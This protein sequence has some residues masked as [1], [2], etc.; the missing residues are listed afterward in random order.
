MR[1]GEW[2][3]AERQQQENQFTALETW[4]SDWRSGPLEG[5]AK[6]S[7]LLVS[8][9][10]WINLY[11]VLT[12]IPMP[13]L[14]VTEIRK[15]ILLAMCLRGLPNAPTDLCSQANK[16]KSQKLRIRPGICPINPRLGFQDGVCSQST[17]LARRVG[18]KSTKPHSAG[19]SVSFARK[20]QL[21]SRHFET[22]E[23]PNWTPLCVFLRIFWGL[24]R[25]HSHKAGFI[26][27]KSHN[28]FK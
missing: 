3:Y 27:D 15:A 23:H 26:S 12:T 14:T 4:D 7:L 25:K 22:W 16:L 11:C 8:L 6:K 9:Y 20:A 24:K 17:P 21:W 1:G 2:G 5:F 19:N 13:S 28:K 18:F 10:C